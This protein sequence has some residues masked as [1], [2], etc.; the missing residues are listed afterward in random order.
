[1]KKLQDAQG[2]VEEA[3]QRMDS[4]FVD[5]QSADG[6]IKISVSASRKVKSIELKPEFVQQADPEELEDHLII[7]LNKALSKAER[8]FETEMAA[9]TKKNMPNIPGL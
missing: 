7:T 8:V 9:V 3:K 2:A 1:M 6:N 4:V 5:E